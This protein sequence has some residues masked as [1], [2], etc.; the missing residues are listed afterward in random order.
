MHEEVGRFFIISRLGEISVL[1][2]LTILYAA[3]K[4]NQDLNES[5][6][7]AYQEQI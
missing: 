7:K 6:Y 5:T 2:G 1:L 3:I 4:I